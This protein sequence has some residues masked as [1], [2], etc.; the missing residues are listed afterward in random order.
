VLVGRDRELAM[1]RTSVKD[2]AAGR[3]G[4]VLVEGEPGVGKSALLASGLADA[5]ELGCR[6]LWGS[7]DELAR[8]FPL[9][10]LLEGLDA[11]GVGAARRTQID[12]TLRG[13]QASGV[14]V[15][16]GGDAV[17]AACEHWRT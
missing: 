17:A 8:R 11:A 15:F 1:L 2:V 13:A 7:A 5:A 10:P 4:V 14:A 9:C 3:G 6:L 16:D 12:R